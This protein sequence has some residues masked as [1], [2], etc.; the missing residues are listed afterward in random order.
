MEKWQQRQ[1]SKNIKRQKKQQ[2]YNVL[3]REVETAM[4]EAKAEV[5]E[6]AVDTAEKQQRR[7]KNNNSNNNKLVDR[8]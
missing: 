4:V 2:K 7:L 6:T 3:S 5:T 8:R 1:W